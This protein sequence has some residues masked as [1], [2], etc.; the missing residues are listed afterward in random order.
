MGES[1]TMTNLDQSWDTSA[2]DF[3]QKVDL[4]VRL[5]NEIDHD[6]I[7]IQH[8]ISSKVFCEDPTQCFLFSIG[9]NPWNFEKLPWRIV[10]FERVRITMLSILT[11]FYLIVIF[12]PII[13]LQTYPKC[14][15][16]RGTNSSPLYSRTSPFSRINRFFAPFRLDEYAFTSSL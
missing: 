7:L 10:Y 11:F 3:G 15:R 16:C 12:S 1:W 2:E 8:F 5:L 9:P 13:S 14:R 6:F 4:T